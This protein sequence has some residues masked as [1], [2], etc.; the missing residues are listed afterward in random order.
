MKNL[1]KYRK[2]L[3]GEL[4]KVTDNLK[5]VGRIN[6]DNPADWEPVPEKMDT[7]PAD[8]NEQA[9]NIEAFEENTAVL[10][11]LEIRFNEIKNALKRIDE[12]RFG[13]CEKCEAEIEEERLDVNPSATTC[14]NHIV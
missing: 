9:D 14:K 13:L 2:I 6:P 10:K 7:T 5:T 4:L 12:G 8:E 3:E 1:E 11:Q